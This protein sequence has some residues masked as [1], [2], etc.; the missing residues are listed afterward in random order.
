MRFE[1][2]ITGRDPQPPLQALFERVLE[3]AADRV[4]LNEK[5]IGRTIIAGRA[6][7]VRRQS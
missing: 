4:A 1:C 6:D 5:M 3:H 7:S 2:D